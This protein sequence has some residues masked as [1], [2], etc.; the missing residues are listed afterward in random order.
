MDVLGSPLDVA[1]VPFAFRTREVAPVMP[2]ARLLAEQRPF[3]DEPG[4]FDHVGFLRGSHRE[5][6][7]DLVERHET[8]TQTA[9][10]P[11]DPRVVP[12][13]LTD[14]VGRHL[15]GTTVDQWR[16]GPGAAR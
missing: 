16:G 9:G 2:A 12:H 7:G 11:V 15:R 10:R 1:L 14:V 6:R 13:D 3:G 8:V 4:G 5:A